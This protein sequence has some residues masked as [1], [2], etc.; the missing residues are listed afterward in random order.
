[1]VRF[2]TQSNPGDRLRRV[3]E[4]E[5]WPSVPPDQL[6][7]QLTKDEEESILGYGPDG[8]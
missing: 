3:L 1:M 7:R 2:P 8:V 4:R 5:I 6:G